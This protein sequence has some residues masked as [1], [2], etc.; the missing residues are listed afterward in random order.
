MGLKKYFGTSPYS[1][2]E[3][4]LQLSKPWLDDPSVGHIVRYEAGDEIFHQKE[5]HPYFYLLR[6]GYASSRVLRRNGAEILLEIFGPGAFFGEGPAFSKSPRPTTARAETP[7]VLSR[8]HPDEAIK[9]FPKN[10]DFAT[11]LI[12][13]LGFKNEMIVNKMSIMTA[14]SPIERVSNLLYRMANVLSM[15]KENSTS[16]NMVD[17]NISHETLAEMTSLTRVSVTRALNEIE[18]AGVILRKSNGKLLLDQKE[19]ENFVNTL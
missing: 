2:W 5:L 6:S 1:A 9:I 15:S 17:I 8:Y 12:K 13:I 11:S 4:S 19:L 7:I 10:I 18:K 16:A 3:C 14:K